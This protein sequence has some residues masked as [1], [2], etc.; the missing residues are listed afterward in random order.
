MLR[1]RTG[2]K[3]VAALYFFRIF[4]QSLKAEKQTQVNW[5][6]AQNGMLKGGAI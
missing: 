2:K 4:R 1:P 5:T 6:L 3:S